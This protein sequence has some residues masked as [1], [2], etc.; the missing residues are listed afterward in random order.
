[1]DESL[2]VPYN[3]QPQVPAWR[4]EEGCPAHLLSAH[5]QWAA[6][7]RA[8]EETRKEAYLLISGSSEDKPGMGLFICDNK[9]LALIQTALHSLCEHTN[10]GEGKTVVLGTLGSRSLCGVQ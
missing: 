5:T 6:K 10:L 8:E 1:M 2:E 3:P 9:P 7:A 4:E